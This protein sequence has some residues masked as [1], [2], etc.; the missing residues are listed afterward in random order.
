MYGVFLHDPCRCQCRR[1]SVLVLEAVAK[2]AGVSNYNHLLELRCSGFG[3][4]PCT[5]LGEMPV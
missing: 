1:A 3:Y 5:D 2:R 4:I